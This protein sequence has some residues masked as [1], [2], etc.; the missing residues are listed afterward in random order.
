M[1]GGGG[2]GGGGPGFQ[3]GPISG[4]SFFE[5]L[6]EEQKGGPGFQTEHQWGKI[7]LKF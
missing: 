2:G 4:G 3:T 5:I 7:F 6:V 1:G